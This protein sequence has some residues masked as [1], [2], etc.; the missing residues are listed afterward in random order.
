MGTFLLYLLVIFQLILTTTALIIGYQKYKQITLYGNTL[1]K[2]EQRCS[3]LLDICEKMVE[4]YSEVCDA[5][6]ADI[7]DR[8][9]D[10][11]NSHFDSKQIIQTRKQEYT[12]A[13]KLAEQGLNITEIAKKVKIGKGEVQLLLDIIG[14]K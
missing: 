6:V 9:N 2:K 13:L 11:K 12:E 7:K 1:E 10:L 8:M 4:D 5:L 3:E 14:K